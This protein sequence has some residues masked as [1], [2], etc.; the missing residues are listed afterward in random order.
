MPIVRVNNR[1]LHPVEDAQLR[2]VVLGI[3]LA[4]FGVAVQAFE[5][6]REKRRLQRV[7]AEIAADPL[8]EIARLGAMV[9][10]QSRFVSQIGV[11][12]HEEAGISESA[13]IFGGIEAE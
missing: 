5:L 12:C 6:D 2:G 4:A 8:V 7:K 9:A 3:S 1:R 10:Q 13:Q 11:A